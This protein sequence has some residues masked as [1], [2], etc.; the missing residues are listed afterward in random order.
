MVSAIIAV[1]FCM[2]A[3]L[4]LLLAITG[5]TLNIMWN[6]VSVI[7]RYTIWCDAVR[8]PLTKWSKKTHTHL[9]DGEFTG[10]IMIL[11]DPQGY[12]LH[13]IIIFSMW[14]SVCITWY[15]R[16]AGPDMYLSPWLFYPLTAIYTL[17]SIAVLALMWCTA[18]SLGSRGE[19]GKRYRGSRVYL[20]ALL[21][22]YVPAVSMCFPAY[23]S[24]SAAL[25]LPPG[26]TYGASELLSLFWYD[27]TWSALYL[28]CIV[29]HLTVCGDSA[30]RVEAAEWLITSAGVS[31]R[32]QRAIDDA[33]TPLTTSL[34]W[35]GR[36][37]AWWRPLAFVSRWWSACADRVLRPGAQGS[38]ACFHEEGGTHAIFEENTEGV[39]EG[40]TGSVLV[41]PT[42]RVLS[43]ACWNETDDMSQYCEWCKCS[44]CGI[45]VMPRHYRR[46][47]EST[48][49]SIWKYVTGCFE[50][51]LPNGVWMSSSALSLSDIESPDEGT[52]DEMKELLNILDGGLVVALLGAAGYS[53]LSISYPYEHITVAA[54]VAWVH[55]VFYIIRGNLFIKPLPSVPTEQT[56][57][58]QRKAA[59]D[60][61]TATSN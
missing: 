42:F 13:S 2:R 49:S 8:K 1:V 15:S 22:L 45:R 33:L 23:L 40:A 44:K 55:L 11:L 4:L 38:D 20:A 61:T 32:A 39:V 10:L 34:S 50:H 26:F 52:S 18:S 3:T 43:C 37:T 19:M 53:Y 48:L 21:L 14:V 17:F 16:L 29:I 27:T 41:G 57:T 56:R 7:L 35:S 28:L 36:G 59:S 25:I 30:C 31:C 51:L 47:A 46:E 54:F 58:G 12:F 5:Y 9:R 6:G 24:A 60:K